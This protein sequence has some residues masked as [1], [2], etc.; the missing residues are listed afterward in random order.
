MKPTIHIIDNFYENPYQVREYALS[1][2]FSLNDKT[3]FPGKRTPYA[4]SSEK[5]LDI[6]KKIFSPYYSDVIFNP[7]TAT[8]MFQYTT[9]N[10]TSWIHKDNHCCEKNDTNN[11]DYFSAVCYLSPN[12]PVESG[13][14]LY[15]DVNDNNIVNTLDKSKQSIEPQFVKTDYVSNKFNRLVL[16]DGNIYHTAETYFGENKYDARLTQVFFLLAIKD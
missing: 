9:K 10:D 13:T 16:F 8:G 5:V 4:Y 12:A 6:F 7:K 15:K 2:Q 1:L 11:F 3:A 14:S